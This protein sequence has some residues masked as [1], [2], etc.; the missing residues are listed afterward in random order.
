MLKTEQNKTKQNKRTLGAWVSS[1]AKNGQKQAWCVCKAVRSGLA[2]IHLLPWVRGNC[3][4]VRN[5]Y[6]AIAQPSPGHNDDGDEPAVWMILSVIGS[7]H[8]V[9]L[10][11]PA[12][13]VGECSFCLFSSRII[14]SPSIICPFGTTSN[15]FCLP[16]AGSTL[17]E[18]HSFITF[19]A[20]ASM[21]A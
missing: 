21:S 8:S 19:C 10:L 20:A 9:V 5:L 16:L 4:C 7:S 11:H 1:E 17:S 12:A 14:N 2:T 13:A 3:I 18:I 15:P 6:H